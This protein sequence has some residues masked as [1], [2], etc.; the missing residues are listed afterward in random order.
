MAFATLESPAAS[1]TRSSA[2]GT[3][4]RSLDALY[5]GCGYLAAASM[6]GILVITML[7]VATRYFHVS[8]TGL[9]EYA[10]YLMAASTFLALA[11]A[12][13]KGTHIRIETVSKLMGG[14]SY[15]LDGAAFLC[16]TAIVSWFGWH[17]CR[18]VYES[19]MFNDISTGLDATPLWIPQLVMAAG[20]VLFAVAMADHTVRLLVTGD[21]GIE[22]SNDVL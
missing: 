15:W 12:L 19:Y 18:M 6:A 8:I 7:Q 9:S 1:K 10:G 3:L 22:A 20:N 11:H 2:I 21:H 16:G 13:N 4:R 5:A 14:K 17:S